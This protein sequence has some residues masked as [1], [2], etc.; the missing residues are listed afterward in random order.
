MVSWFG[1]LEGMD[2]ATLTNMLNGF[3]C[4]RWWPALICYPTE[5]P[6]KIQSLPHSVGEFPVYFFGSRDYFWLTSGRCF[7][8]QEGDKGGVSGRTSLAYHF[9][10]GRLNNSYWTLVN[11]KDT[12]KIEW[13]LF[14]NNRGNSQTMLVTSFSCLYC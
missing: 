13:N 7:K 6:E 14:K 9:Q 3:S 4:H 11:S 10:K 1:W 2:F 8:Y 5:V 12:R